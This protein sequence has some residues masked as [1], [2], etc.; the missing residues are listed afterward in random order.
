MRRVSIISVKSY[1][2]MS[3]DSFTP[4]LV[5]SLSLKSKHSKPLSDELR[6]I[7]SAFYV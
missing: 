6:L 5:L 3:I 4:C 2:L 7:H 1:M